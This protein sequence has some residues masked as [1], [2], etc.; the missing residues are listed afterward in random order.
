MK[1]YHSI[2]PNP[3]LVRLFAVAKGLALPLHEIDILAGENRQPEYLRINPTGTTPVLELDDGVCIAETIAI[4]EY[5]EELYPEPMLI[6][7]TALE[8]ANT[9]MWLRRVEQMIIQ[10]MTAGF[11]GAEGLDLFQDRVACYP[12]VTDR[13]KQE[14]RNGW[15]WLEEQLAD[16]RDYICGERMTAAD[17]ALLSFA[18]FGEAVGQPL[19]DQCTRLRQWLTCMQEW[20]EKVE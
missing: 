2:G 12:E 10:P 16:G 7:Q 1:L 18:G 13:Y 19:P 11:R 9:R 3:R 6:G 14:A 4:C 5:L 20:A 15:L 17:V 8:R